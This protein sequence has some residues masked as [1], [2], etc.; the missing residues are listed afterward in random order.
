[1]CSFTRWVL[2][3]CVGL[4][5]R[6]PLKFLID[7]AFLHL[8]RLSAAQQALAVNRT[9]FDAYTVYQLFVEYAS[10]VPRDTADVMVCAVSRFSSSLRAS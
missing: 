1:M 2:H 8:T 5:D 3:D 4:A 6:L 10:T 9:V 7:A